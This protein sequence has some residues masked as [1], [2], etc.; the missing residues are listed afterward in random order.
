MGRVL[1][2][3]SS[4]NLGVYQATRS[5]IGAD[6]DLQKL[7]AKSAEAGLFLPGSVDSAIYEVA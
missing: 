2:V 7:I 5:K 3:S 1:V 4:E 6:P